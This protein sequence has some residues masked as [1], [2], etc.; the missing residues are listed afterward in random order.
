MMEL[1]ELY[2]DEEELEFPGV[3][4]LSLVRYPAI[5]ANFV[6]FNKQ[7]ALAKLDEERR[8]LVGPALIPEKKIYRQDP[9]GTE[10][11]VYFTADTVKK[12]AHL[13]MRN[14]KMN[15]ATVE[16][17]VKT[18]QVYVYESWVVE[19]VKKDKQQVYGMKYPKGTWMVSMRVDSDEL[20]Q[21]IKDG[22]LRGISI[23]G[24]FVDRLTSPKKEKEEMEILSQIRA[25]AKRTNLFAEETLQDGTKL[26]TEADAFEPGVKVQVLDEEGNPQDAPTGEHTLQN[27][28][29]IT[30]GE[31]SILESIGKEEEPVAAE[32][33]KKE[34]EE[35]AEMEEHK[36]EDKDKDKEKDERMGGY[37]K[38]IKAA[39]AEAEVPEE[40]QDM[41]VEAVVVVVDEIVQE[42]VAPVVEDAVE[43]AVEEKIEEVVEEKVEEVAMSAEILSELKKL[44][45]RVAQLEDAPAADFK[46]APT[47][48]NQVKDLTRMSVSERVFNSL[49]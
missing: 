5:E 9:D 29:V 41:L 6:F 14:S 43:E 19:N 16:H 39:L 26:V 15:A 32:E 38:R 8:M 33:E 21:G 23:E 28:T 24:F 25:F 11:E 35:K 49:R 37:R 40:A 27:G 22:S 45:A 20:W 46:H 4:A 17:E 30:V 44:S 34:E 48:S 47:K 31:G 12:A 7:F 2:I 1:R 10:Y 3:E 13:F 18:D 42:A 36:E